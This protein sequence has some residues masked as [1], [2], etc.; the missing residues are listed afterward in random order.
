MKTRQSLSNSLLY[1]AFTGGIGGA[2]GGGLFGLFVGI[3]TD[4]SIEF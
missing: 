1:G 2:L 3:P 4:R